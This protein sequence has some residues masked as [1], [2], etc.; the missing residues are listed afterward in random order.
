MMKAMS[1]R[2]L[3]TATLRELLGTDG[4]LRLGSSA[5]RKLTRGELGDGYADIRWLYD[6]AMEEGNSEGTME[7]DCSGNP[8]SVDFSNAGTC[9]LGIV[10]EVRFAHPPRRLLKK[11]AVYPEDM[12]GFEPFEVVIRYDP[13][14]DE[15]GEEEG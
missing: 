11:E 13:F 2:L 8:S 3:T 1:N 6:C 10:C 9:S 4:E 7:T 14:F 5:V 12:D 15:S